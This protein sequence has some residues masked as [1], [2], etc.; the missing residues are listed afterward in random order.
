MVWVPLNRENFYPVSTVLKFGDLLM[1]E[2]SANIEFQL[3]IFKIMTGRPK[4]TGTWG[5]NASIVAL[6]Q[7]ILLIQSI[8]C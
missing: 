8:L 5:L 7:K 2:V 1:I 6:F 3:S 4:N